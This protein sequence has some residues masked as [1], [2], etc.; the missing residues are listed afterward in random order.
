[1]TVRVGA[2]DWVVAPG[3]GERR[4]GDFPRHMSCVS[5][6]GSGHVTDAI[7]PLHAPFVAEAVA[8][9]RL[10]E[11]GVFAGAMSGPYLGCGHDGRPYQ[12]EFSLREAG[13]ALLRLYHPA[14]E[15]GAEGLTPAC[16]GKIG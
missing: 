8:Q 5:A 7:L 11:A 6:D 14:R 13:A 1:V 10:V 4:I 9:G 15:G 16:A 3:S 12:V 2:A